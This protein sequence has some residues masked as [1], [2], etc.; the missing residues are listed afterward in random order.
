VAWVLQYVRDNQQNTLRIAVN[1]DGD[2]SSGNWDLHD[3]TPTQIDPN[4]TNQWFDYNHVTISRNF[5]YVV[6]NMFD[7]ND[8]FT[9]CVVFRF[10]L[11]AL[12]EG[13]LDT[14][15]LFVA[16]NDYFSLRATEGA[17]D[18][19]FFFAHKSTATMTVFRWPET[20]TDPTSFDVDVSPW[21]RGTLFSQTPD[22]SNWLQRG[23]GRITGAWAAG[24]KI[25]ALWMG[26]AK[27]QMPNPFIRAICVDTMTES[28]IAEPD[29]WT[30]DFALGYPSA[31]VNKNGQVGVTL[32]YGGGTAFVNHAVGKLDLDTM[33]WSLR[34]S[35]L[36]TNG[37][38]DNKCGDYL[39]CSSDTENDAGWISSGFTLNG[40][41]TRL[42]VRPH[43][44]F[45]T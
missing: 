36:G 20:D 16:P 9:Q 38:A 7:F 25:G 45:F 41:R 17:N 35:V 32:L 42:F 43:L 21:T 29:M 24:T 1:T 37:P 34:R 26:N 28:L 40:G 3:L 23:D 12:K 4:W 30:P 19:I 11:D 10:S 5:L 31:G 2:L 18:E 6:T 15:D 39:C 22:G 8:S 44:V 33:T 27:D 14:L 13:T